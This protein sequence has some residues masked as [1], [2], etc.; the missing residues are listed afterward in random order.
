[1]A[2]YASQTNVENAVGGSAALVWITDLTN[3]AL[4][5]NALAEALDYAT[6]TIDSHVV[7][8]G[9]TT[10]TAGAM[11]SSTPEQAIAACVTLAVY[12]LYEAVRREVPAQWQRAYER[13][14]KE[15]EAL[16]DGKVSWVVSESPAVVNAQAVYYFGPGSTART[17]NP[18]RTLRSHLDLL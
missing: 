12:R 9:G 6:A 5:S 17:A 7:G 18:R 2:T 13:T 14:I 8:L 3:T 15:L 10:G 16:R 11:W 1:M 4:N